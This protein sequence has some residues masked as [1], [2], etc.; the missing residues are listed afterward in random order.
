MAK[1]TPKKRKKSSALHA[2]RPTTVARALLPNET[3]E[4]GGSARFPLGLPVYKVFH[5]IEFRGAIARYHEGTRLCDIKYVGGDR[6]S[7]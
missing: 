3:S 2:R 4:G 6:C 1:A 7:E 5:G